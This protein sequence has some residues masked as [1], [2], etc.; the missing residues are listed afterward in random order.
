MAIRLPPR[1]TYASVTFPQKPHAHK[2]S[3]GHPQHQ[4]FEA[5]PPAKHL[6][7]ILLGIKDKPHWAVMTTTRRGPLWQYE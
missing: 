2:P 3:M 5:G 7:C 6:I 1:N 4:N